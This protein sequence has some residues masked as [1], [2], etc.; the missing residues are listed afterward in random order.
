[1]D[2]T[3]TFLVERQ[4]DS[5]YPELCTTS[6]IEHDLNVK[7]SNDWCISA[8]LQGARDNLPLTLHIILNSILD[9]IWTPPS[10]YRLGCWSLRD[11]VLIVWLPHKAPA[12]RER[13]SR[14]A[15]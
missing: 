9:F 4:E 3:D 13:H 6:R 15:R 5:L 11:S 14:P 7:N 2:T 1:V 12:V 10:D 8:G